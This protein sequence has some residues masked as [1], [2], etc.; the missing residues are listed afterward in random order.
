MKLTKLE[1]ERLYA[2]MSIQELADH[3]GMARSTLYYHMSK[4][5]VKRRSKSAAQKSYTKKHGHQRLG[6]GHTEESKKK[7]QDG[8][9]SF[10][11][12]E[13]GKLQKDRL[14]E[15]RKEEWKNAS[16]AKKRKVVNRLVNSDKPIP[17]TLSKFGKK[18]V[19]FLSESEKVVSGLKLTTDHVSD[20]MLPERRVVVELVL[21]VSVYGKEAEHK[22]D[23]RY[24]RII[25]ELNDQ[26]YRVLVI[27]DSSNSV[28]IARCKRAAEQI[29]L[30]DES[31]N[32]HA[33]VKL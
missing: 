32:N 11:E 21:P 19:E 25:K 2:E 15:A 29:K 30:L 26:K 8:A 28:S 31:G 18:L 16:S 22:L 1:L 13:E 17:G 12:S 4:L 10:W 27:I 9:K 14:A 20:I 7:I 23:V 33:T 5:G 3:L 24:D 6:R